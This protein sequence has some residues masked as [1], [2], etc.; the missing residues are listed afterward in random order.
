MWRGA[1][2]SIPSPTW[3]AASAWAQPTGIDLPGE[4]AGLIPDTAWKQA[5]FGEVW[6]PGE[7]LIA[8]IGQGFIPATPLQLAV[9][10]GAP[11]PM[12]AMRCVPHLTRAGEA[13]SDKRDATRRSLPAHGMSARRI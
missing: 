8:G 4:K 5:T 11:R 2:A 6:Q 7:T 13:D 12:A 3:R 1:S 9:D 10:G